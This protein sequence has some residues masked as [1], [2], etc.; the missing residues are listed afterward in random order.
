MRF[1]IISNLT[2]GAGLQ[3]DYLLLKGLLEAK[4]HVV[5]GVMY[6]AAPPYPTADVNLWLEIMPSP[7]WGLLPIALDS[8]P[9][10]WLI[11]N[12]EWWYGDLWDQYLPRLERILCKTE[13]SL[14]IFRQKL[15]R[16]NWGDRTQFIGFEALDFYHPEIE[17]KLRFLHM[18]GKSETKNTA[19]VMD[20]W[21][22][23]GLP[24]P[25]T[26]VAWKPNIAALCRG[27]NVTHIER[28]EEDQMPRM[29][30]EHQFHIMP[31]KYEGFGHYIHE[32]IGCGGVVITTDAEPMNGFR[33]VAQ[34]LLIPAVQTQSM[35]AATAHLVSGAG[36]A[37]AVRK[38]ASLAKE[39][40]AQIATAAREA[41]LVD[42]ERFR[43][44]FGALI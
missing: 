14:R 5:A 34:E 22:R 27:P 37:A 9:R 24:Y 29:M 25:L 33:G 8:A 35:R 12:P 23:H 38:A 31:S 44:A 43:I 28:V 36:V 19:A 1:N 39:R 40:I 6:D 41:F 17:R 32:A 15:A 21:Q 4:G 26:V 18:A 10:N 16:H 42:R 20:A 13:D 11:P 7:G 30:N 2:N 3:R